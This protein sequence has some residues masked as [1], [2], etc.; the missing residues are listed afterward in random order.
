MFW[1]PK[2]SPLRKRGVCSGSGSGSGVKDADFALVLAVILHLFSLVG[3]TVAWHSIFD[4]KRLF[5]VGVICGH[6]NISVLVERQVDT[7]VV[8]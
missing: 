2:R 1:I 4:S 7:T 6:A 3:S 8:L 5:M